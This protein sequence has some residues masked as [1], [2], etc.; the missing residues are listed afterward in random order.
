MSKTS[1]GG[2]IPRNMCPS[3]SLELRVRCAFSPIGRVRLV[4]F[5][6]FCYL[7]AILSGCHRLVLL[8]HA[9]EFRLI[10]YVHA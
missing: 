9:G 6:E 10:Q 4:S 8:Q 7:V 1:W 5:C 2:G 3:L